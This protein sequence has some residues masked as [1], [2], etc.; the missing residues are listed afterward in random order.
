MGDFLRHKPPT[1]VGSN[2][3]LDADD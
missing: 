1:F 3:P 2:N